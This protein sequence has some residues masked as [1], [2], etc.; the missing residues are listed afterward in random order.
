MDPAIQNNLIY[1]TIVAKAWEDEA[2]LNRL[3]A[4]PKDVLIEE[5]MDIPEEIEIKVKLNTPNLT[6]VVL[7]V[8]NI[9][10]A[11]DQLSK[12][13]K[14][15]LPFPSDHSVTIIQNEATLQY[16][17]I[18]VNPSEGRIEI[19]EDQLE[20]VVGGD[21]VWHGVNIVAYANG[22]VAANGL[23]YQNG[24]LATQAAAVAVGITLAV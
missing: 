1:S 10:S 2:Y 17:V 22:F 5:G 15:A 12:A 4:R 3:I 11:I 16:C 6:H 21:F 7:P 19:S 18:P 13:L 9:E 8:G 23:V 20:A 14:D 24:A